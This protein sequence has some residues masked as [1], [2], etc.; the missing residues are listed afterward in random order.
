M[1]DNIIKDQEKRG[2]IER[3]QE[4]EDK[5][6]RAHYIPHHPVKKDSPT[7]PIR[8][9]FDCSCKEKHGSASLNDC[10]ETNAPQLNDL[11]I[12]LTKFRKNNYAVTTDIEKAFLQIGL[13]EED[14]DYT[15]FFWLRDY[16]DPDSEII[17]YRF[18][19]VLFGAT[20]S[21]FILNATLLKLFT[22]NSNRTSLELE[23]S[24]YV[25]N[26]LTSF[27]DE[28]SLLRFYTEAR[29]LLQKGGLICAHEIQTAVN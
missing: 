25:D 11:P 19:V 23:R 10:L 29:H 12:L 22:D 24:L 4:G 13:E 1:Y 17:T 6:E 18:K 26:V 7:T 16:T 28:I 14:R 8:I 5:N 2:F 20:C 3:V 9:V 21:P 15:I 27:N